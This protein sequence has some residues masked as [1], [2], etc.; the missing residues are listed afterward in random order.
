MVY[1][2]R[3]GGGAD[4]RGGRAD[5]AWSWCGWCYMVQWYAAWKGGGADVHGGGADEAQSWCGW[6][7]MVQW[8]AVRKGGGADACGGRADVS[9][10]VMRLALHGAMVCGEEGRRRGCARRKGR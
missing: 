10:T 7:C 8:Y 1:A 4:V 2:A 3:K 9:T 6:R 5:E